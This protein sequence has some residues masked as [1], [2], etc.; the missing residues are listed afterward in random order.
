MYKRQIKKVL[1]PEQNQ[2]DAEELD[3]ELT[4]GMELVYVSDMS[5]VELSLIHISMCIR[6]SK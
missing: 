2:P 5:Q 6:D 3:A 4:E 1:I